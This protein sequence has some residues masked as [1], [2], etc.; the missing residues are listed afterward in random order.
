MPRPPTRVIFQCLALAV[1]T[2]HAGFSRPLPSDEPRSLNAVGSGA[3]AQ[4]QPAGATDSGTSA[5]GTAAA[6][7]GPAVEAPDLLTS[8]LPLDIATSS[9]YELVDWARSLGLSDSG[10]SD[11]LRARLYDHYAV[12]PATAVTGGGKTVVIKAANQASYAGGAGDKGVVSLSGGVVLTIAED[13]GSNYTISARTVI[14]DRGRNSVYAAGTVVYTRTTQGRTEEFRGSTLAADLDD[15]S[16]LFLDGVWRQQ[17]ASLGSSDRGLTFS[18]SSLERISGDYITLGDATVSPGTGDTPNFSIRAKRLW[19]VGESDWAALSALVYVGEV[20]VLW[21]PFFYY[22]SEEILFHPVFGFRSREG[23]FLQTTTWLL[24]Q[25]PAAA[26]NSAII[27]FSQTSGP[28]EVRGI[29]LKHIP[30]GIASGQGAPTPSPAASSAA[31]AGTAATPGQGTAAAPV[32]SDSVKLL[33]DWYT[34][35]GAFVG[36]DASLKPSGLVTRFDLTSGVG[37]SR[38]LFPGIAGL[39]SPFSSAGAWQSIW[40]NSDVFGLVLPFRFGGQLS[41]GLSLGPVRATLDL[42]VYSDS[43]FEQDFRNRSYDMDWLGMSNATNALTTSTISVRSSLSQKLSLTG[44]LPVAVLSPWLQNAGLT[45]NSSFNWLSKQDSTIPNEAL[46]STLWSA[47]PARQFFYP[48]SIRPVDMSLSLGGTLLDF[49]GSAAASAAKVAASPASGPAS[50]APIPDLRSPWDK[51]DSAAKTA[52]DS[53]GNTGAAAKTP[54]LAD[55]DFP[56]PAAAPDPTLAA[57]PTPLSSKVSWSFQPGLVLER[58]FLSDGWNGASSVDYTPLWDLASVRLGATI[59]SSVA[60]YGTA[61]TGSYNLAWS[62]QEQARNTPDPA[63]FSAGSS[64]SGTINAVRLSDA[65]YASRKL[66]GSLSLASQPLPASSIFSPS[67]VSWTFNST[68]FSWAFDKFTATDPN[69]GQYLPSSATYVTHF[70]EWTNSAISANNLGLTLAMKT[71]S[72]QQS[73]AFSA[74][75]P[76]LTESYAA[77]LGLAANSVGWSLTLGGQ[78]RFVRQTSGNL[79]ASPLTASAKVAA[80]FGLSISD[81]LIWDFDLMN[82]SSNS[83]SATWG[84]VTA[85]LQSQYAQRY[86]ILSNAWSLTGSPSFIPTS[87]SASFAPRLDP[88]KDADFQPTLSSSLSYTQSLLRFSDSVMTFG[89]SVDLKLGA[90]FA[91]NLSSQSQ[92]R[93]AWRYWPQLLSIP[94][95]LGSASSYMVNPIIDIGNSLAIWNSAALQNAN[96]KLKSLSF[97]LSQDLDDWTLSASASATPTLSS[98]STYWYINPSFTLNIAWKDIPMMKSNITGTYDNSSKLMQFSW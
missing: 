66:N 23:S 86:T 17:G 49:P 59:G 48:D 36:L 19:F 35:L 30:G 84:W 83:A 82:F 31:A 68:L 63:S 94:G 16:G 55:P 81:S 98:D 96:F 41:L 34:G 87:F 18:S 89:L 51:G 6:V 79:K 40:N 47:D 45:L 72:T 3:T 20:P 9:Y 11:D 21:L 97:K 52:A 71:G 24:G 7:K 53:A 4:D 43:F 50:S 2:A 88:P 78:E 12:K 70:P 8:T 60:L 5:D 37:F 33:G 62:E 58:R 28:T 56:E 29:F 76:P 73:L 10:S 67:S 61:L 69:T 42:P 39:S 75:L 74:S 93:N 92:N 80:P 26:N 32:S 54:P 22:P 13:G 44:N 25:K 95:S 64:A 15:W 1:L 65:Q 57:P 77:T 46:N 14:Y 38:S 90:G 27:Q 85:T 91:L